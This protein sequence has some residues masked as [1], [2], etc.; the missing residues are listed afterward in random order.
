MITKDLFDCDD[1]D[2]IKFEL[3][4]IVAAVN[5]LLDRVSLSSYRYRLVIVFGDN[6]DDMPLIF[7]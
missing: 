5:N 6:G 2:S 7:D 3:M 1:R 4:P